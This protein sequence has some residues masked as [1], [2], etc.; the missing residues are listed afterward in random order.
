MGAAF[1]GIVPV[2]WI[3][4]WLLIPKPYRSR[5]VK[6]DVG[7][8]SNCGYDLQGLADRASCPEC[9]S[10][11]R[12]R[13]IDPLATKTFLRFAVLSLAGAFVLAITVA[14]ACESDNLLGAIGFANILFVFAMAPWIGFLMFA[15]NSR[16][17]H[18]ENIMAI[19]I[20]NFA[21]ML[22]M[23]VLGIPLL[24]ESMGILSVSILASA[25]GSIFAV[26][27]AGACRYWES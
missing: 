16:R 9:G 10:R 23:T 22:G 11:S 26:I 5:V 8:C 4:T 2:F 3:I 27:A 24:R 17:C 20:A 6:R 7:K 18:E 15:L 21:G 1:L 13:L 19:G 14:A 25:V 12:G